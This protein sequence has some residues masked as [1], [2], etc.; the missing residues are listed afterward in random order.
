MSR[1]GP[2]QAKESSMQENQVQAR[3]SPTKYPWNPSGHGP[4][5]SVKYVFRTTQARP[6]P[7][8]GPTFLGLDPGPSFLGRASGRASGR[9]AH[10]QVDGDATALLTIQPRHML[11]SY[12]FSIIAADALF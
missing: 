4:G 7:T 1:A 5:R 9:A 10:G 2:G 12:L 3:P 11:V 6:D 8:I